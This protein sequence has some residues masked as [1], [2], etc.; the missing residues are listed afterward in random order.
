MNAQLVSVYMTQL[1]EDGEDGEAVGHGRIKPDTLDDES[2]SLVML[3]CVW[4]MAE[5]GDINGFLAKRPSS[6]L[7]TP[8]SPSSRVPV[9]AG[10]LFIAAHSTL[11][12]VSNA[13]SCRRPL[14]HRP[15]RPYRCPERWWLPEPSSPLPNPPSPPS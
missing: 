10:G 5:H 9:G 6:L 11:S 3:D 4:R 2:S 1:V 12:V 7:P 15:L 8:P 14:H 13:G